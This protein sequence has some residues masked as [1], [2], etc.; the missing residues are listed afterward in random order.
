MVTTIEYALMAGDSYFDTR[1][2]AAN[3]F[4]IPTGWNL[5]SRNPGQ[6]WGQVLH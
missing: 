6:V 2:P 5:V 3:R 4:P 1:L